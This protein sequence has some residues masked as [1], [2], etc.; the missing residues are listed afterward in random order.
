MNSL[1]S[2]LASRAA[3][4]HACTR[5]IDGRNRKTTAAGAGLEARRARSTN[6][7]RMG[8]AFRYSTQLTRANI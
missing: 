8:F 7:A 5:P 2:A 1:R 4:G 3:R 6:A